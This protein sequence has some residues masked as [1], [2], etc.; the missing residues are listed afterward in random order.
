MPSASRNPSTAS[1]SSPAQPDGYSK[2]SKAAP[3][4]MPSKG[5]ERGRTGRL[6]AG[7][8]KGSQALRKARDG[9]VIQSRPPA[10]APTALRA[11]PGQFQNLQHIRAVA[12]ETGIKPSSPRAVH[13]APAGTRARG[14]AF[15]VPAS[16]LP[17]LIP[18][19]WPTSNATHSREAGGAWPRLR[20]KHSRRLVPP[21][22]WLR[23]RCQREGGSELWAKPSL[24]QR[25]AGVGACPVLS[26]V[27]RSVGRTGSI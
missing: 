1:A 6:G 23:W 8:G 14:S 13:P 5:A 21:I 11:K 10:P 4:W 26:A 15:E 25:D 27:G 22:L 3:A 20:R 12:S 9:A 19:R 7:L 16:P 2:A 24:T 18:L 17:R